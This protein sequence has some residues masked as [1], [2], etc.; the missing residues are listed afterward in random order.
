MY[1]T[2]LDEKNVKFNMADKGM[3]D[4]SRASYCA[5]VLR[6]NRGNRIEKNAKS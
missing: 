4:T 5:Y 3:R 1:R 6:I 2:E